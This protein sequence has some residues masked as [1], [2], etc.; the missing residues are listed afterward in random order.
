MDF[1]VRLFDKDRLLLGVY[2]PSHI[3]ASTPI[4]SKGS[5]VL[6]GFI[7]LPENIT[8][9]QYWMSIALAHPNVAFKVTFQDEIKLEIEGVTALNGRAFEY[10][11]CGFLMLK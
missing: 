4:I 1:E 7:P 5:F 11:D 9:G 8:H 3:N 6:A 2:S 10:K